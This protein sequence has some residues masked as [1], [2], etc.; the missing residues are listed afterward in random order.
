MKASVS[1]LCEKLGVGRGLRA[2]ESHQLCVFDDEG[3]R[4]C[5]AEVRLSGDERELEAIYQIGHQTPSEGKPPIEVRFYLKTKPHSGDAHA[6]CALRIEG[7]DEVNALYDWEGKACKVF[8]RV[9]RALEKNEVPDFKAILDEEWVSN[10]RFGGG[11]QGGGKRNP[12]A[13]IDNL[14]QRGRGF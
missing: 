9:L 11:R 1:E 4:S 14:L 2:Y 7:E 13:K 8:K 12:K 5:T 6:I 3:D 10:E